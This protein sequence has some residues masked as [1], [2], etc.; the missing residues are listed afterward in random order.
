MI[1]D[2]LSS[3]FHTPC[4]C[5]PSRSI[6]ISQYLS[7][8]LK[9]SASCHPR[10][11]H[12]SPPRTDA[13]RVTADVSGAVEID[14]LAALHAWQTNPSNFGCALMRLSGGTHS[15]RFGEATTA[16]R[17]VQDFETSY[18]SHAA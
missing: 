7:R 9:A 10:R 15:P 17:V 11:W 16:V 5:A 14:L 18:F 4:Q 12:R 13:S 8:L 1:C 2:S 6:A 3:P